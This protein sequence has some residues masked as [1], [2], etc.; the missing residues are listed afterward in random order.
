MPPVPDPTRRF[1]DRVEHYTR[2]RPSYP[3]EV[4]GVL[5]RRTGFQPGSLVADIGAGTGISTELFLRHGSSVFAVEPNAEMRAE[6]ERRLS[7][8]ST[9]R[10]LAG[11]AEATSLPDRSVDYIVAA[12]AFHWFDR[13]T[14]RRE[15]ARI[16]RPGGWIV[17][18]W[19]DRR[20]DRTPFLREYEALLQ[21][22]GT[23]YLTVRQNNIQLE[24]LRAFFGTE[25]LAV[26][27]LP[28]EQRLDLA[29]LRGR[30]L[31]SSYV[32]TEGD[33]RDLPR[34]DALRDLYGRHAED[35]LV[36]IEYDTR[37][38]LGQI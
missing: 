3:D 13:D 9:F 11:T 1:S 19:N 29:A 21:Q 36:T 37:I 30:L 16:L 27:T 26:E 33:P 28:N 17:I 34:M 24:D 10:S 35:G 12:Q 14:A 15:F 31:S 22:F 32:P 5:R 7:N 20:L 6:A 25:R 4:I 2:Y 38:Y 23:D 18:L 8:Y